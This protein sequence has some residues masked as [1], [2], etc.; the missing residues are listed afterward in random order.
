[1]AQS[2]TCISLTEEENGGTPW[3]IAMIS[4]DTLS[5]AKRLET[6]GVPAQQAEAHAMALADILMTQAASK[7]D[8]A[9]LEERLK[10]YIKEQLAEQK[11][12]ML[13]WMFA[14]AIGQTSLIMLAIRYMPH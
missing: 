14:S 4:I 3:E 9:T 6:A 5:Y 12:E 8:L 11:A 10:L 7:A 13:K 2:V 1:M